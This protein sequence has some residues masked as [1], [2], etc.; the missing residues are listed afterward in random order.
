MRNR[1]FTLLFSVAFLPGYS[2]SFEW[3]QRAGRYAFD[4]G[5][6]VGA[7]NAGNVYIA[8]KYEQNAYFG[9]T[10]V[11]CAGNHDMYLAKYSPSGTFRWVRTAGGE[12]GDYAHAI[13]VDGAGNSY[14]TGEFEVTTYFGSIAVK[15][16]GG[17]DVFVA[18]YDTNGNLLWVKKL[19]GGTKSD[20]GLGITVVGSSVY[21]TGKFEGQGNFAGTTLT[22]AGGRDIF[23]AKYTTSGVFQWAKRAGGSGDDEGF[24]ISNDTGGNIYVTGYF[25]GTASFN[26]VPLTTKGGTDIF[27]AKYNASGGLIWLKKAGG[28]SDDMANAIKV[29]NSNRVFLTGSFRNT[30]TFGSLSLTANAGGHSDVFIA[31]YDVSGNATWVK[32]GGGSDNDAGRA[33]AAD[34]AGNTFITGNCGQTATFG[35]TTL[36]GADATELFFASYD[37]SGNFRWVLKAGGEADASDPDR[38]I[39]MGLS[40]CTDPTGNVFASGTYRSSSTFGSTT[41]APWSTHTEVFLTKIRQGR[42]EQSTILA[43]IE[44]SGTASYCSGGSVNLKAPDDSTYTYQ[45]MRNGEKI[46]GATGASCTASAPGDYAVLIFSGGDSLLSEK[47]VVREEKSIT[48][49]I[50]ASSPVFCRDSNEVLIANAGENYL[51][52]WKRDGVAIR[53]ATSAFY[54]PDRSGDYQVKIIQGSCFDWSPVLKV[55]V[56]N[57]GKDSL[58]QK[59]DAVILD[60][61]NAS[62]DSLTVKIYPNP[63]KGVFTLEVNMPGAMQDATVELVNVIGQVVYHH[64][65]A[66]V[67]GYINEHIELDSAVP[68]GIYFLQVTTGEVVEKTRMMLCR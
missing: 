28:T 5:Y 40:I 32:K 21:V 7:D 38:F 27:I 60:V 16:N 1:I 43:T 19:G 59:P 37:V 18:K 34:A 17:N 35:S 22:S 33:I 49:V 11:G 56:E 41:L 26:G 54:A 13:A 20:K 31:R 9:G 24:A 14:V 46:P 52:Q 66:S 53:G 6:G 47:T 8:G 10:Y 45:W 42:S 15:S 4:L 68:T 23:I 29:D 64:A 55:K 51:Y 67:N 12:W 44:P 58:N 62:D 48:A 3:A 2:Q 25:S 63:N 39:E 57:C 65:V 36:H 50:E 30:S 61:Q